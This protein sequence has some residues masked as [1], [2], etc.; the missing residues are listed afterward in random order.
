MIQAGGRFSPQGESRPPGLLSA[1]A[2]ERA[3][4][5]RRGPSRL[6]AF[7]L[8]IAAYLSYTYV[9]HSAVVFC[10]ASKVNT[11]I[12]SPEKNATFSVCPVA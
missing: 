3:P 4:R 7:S 8:P 5:N 10:I 1:L 12:S 9:P 6:I 2:Q 11:G